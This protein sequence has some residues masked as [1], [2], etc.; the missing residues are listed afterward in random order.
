MRPRR[1]HHPPHPLAMP[2]PRR[3]PTVIKFHKLFRRHFAGQS[4]LIDQQEEIIAQL[5]ATNAALEHIADALIAGMDE[6]QLAAF[7]NLMDGREEHRVLTRLEK[8]FKTRD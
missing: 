5:T 4:M 6:Y 8:E 1:P 2:H 3:G 7:E